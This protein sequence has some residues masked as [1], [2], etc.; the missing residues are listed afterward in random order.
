[1]FRSTIL[2]SLCL[3][4]SP[5]LSGQTSDLRVL[6][7]EKARKVNHLLEQKQA[8]GFSGS[9]I[10]EEKGE[11]TLKVAH[12]YANRS[13][14]IP[15][16]TTTISTI[17]SI[18]KPFTA[19]A[20]LNLE[21]QGKLDL[22]DPI[23]KFISDLNTKLQSITIHQLLT[24]QSGLG[25]IL[26]GN[27]FRVISRE[28]F[29]LRLKEQ[30]LRFKPGE[31]VSYS[32][33]GY[34]VLAYIIEEI[35]GSSY[36]EYIQSN[37]L[38]P[39]G[40]HNTGYEFHSWNSESLAVGY[41]GNSEWGTVYEKIKTT[42]G[43]YWNLIGN[44]GLHTNLDDMY[45]WYLAM[46]NHDLISESMLSKLTKPHVKCSPKS[47]TCFQS[48]A[49]LALYRNDGKDLVAVSHS[50]GNDILHAD[51]FWYPEEEIFVFLMTNNSKFPASEVLDEV[52]AILR[53]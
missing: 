1:M 51:F 37:F 50:G 19:T 16:S 13:R 30:R 44:G 5:H 4:L 48:Y 49:W 28:D 14:K 46:K 3:L 29:I 31:K 8:K 32:N 33:I 21:E 43:N 9:I 40:M 17:G 35:S 45:K 42:N 18:T 23:S 36:E 10:V 41:R 12:G 11:V 47:I 6:K 53:N 38:K 7:G 27:D 26:V 15:Y 34:T 52:R 22:N 25:S 24:H 20:I 2:L 39:L